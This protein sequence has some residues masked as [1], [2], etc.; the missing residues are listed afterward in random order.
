MAA[1]QCDQR[2]TWRVTPKRLGQL[3]YP[4]EPARPDASAMDKW[5]AEHAFLNARQRAVEDGI[6]R[7]C[8]ARP[9]L[10]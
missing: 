10:R 5:A 7:G 1:H 9:S 6:L 8:T 3:G 2:C 4:T